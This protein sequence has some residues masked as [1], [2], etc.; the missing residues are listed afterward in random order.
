MRDL[1]NQYMQFCTAWKVVVLA[2]LF[3]FARPVF[4]GNFADVYG[5]H[6]YAAGM[7]G[8][9]TSF[10]N[11]SSAVFYN[12][13]GLGAVSRFENLIARSQKKESQ[14][15][16]SETSAPWW[17]APFEGAITRPPALRPDNGYS[18]ELM[19][20]YNYA[21]P[22][23]K[24]NAPNNQDIANIKDHNAG[25]GLGLN[26]SEVYDLDRNIRFGLEIQTPATGN[27]A[28][29]N[30]LNPTVH[31]YLQNGVS[32]ERPVIMGG[33]GAEIWKDHLFVGV[34]FTMLLKGQGAILLKD[35]PISPQTVVPDQQVILELKPLV[36]PTYGIMFH[37]G[38]F[39]VGVSYRRE[40]YLSVDALSARA[41]TTLL[42]I[43][44]DFDLALLDLHMPRTR[45]Y[46][47][48]YELF[49]KWTL[50]IDI[51]RELWSRIRLSRAKERY[52]EDF[53]FNDITVYRAGIEYRWLDW[54][55]LRGG[56][57]RRPTPLPLMPGRNNWMDSDRMIY[58]VGA[59][60]YLIP[61][62]PVSEDGGLRNPITLDL[63]VQNQQ[64][65]PVD[66]WKYNPTENN[67]FY[68]YSGN[69]W[70]GGLAVTFTL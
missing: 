32:N 47:F 11:D 58:S 7:S 18:H 9:V 65:K 40:T 38:R 45:S 43:Q 64:F 55:S 30:D 22:R 3:I 68:S 35:V 51:N 37:Y 49:E 48:A 15:H 59:S 36:N 28:T 17:K 33:L 69:A 46:G 19:L 29:V 41:Q 67:P 27:L 70:Y 60:L 5:A 16:A 24:T 56:I 62:Y 10:V 26:L 20:M 66:V 25:I 2:A 52:S 6:P 4:A 21:K 63:V 12:V 8:S 14:E 34:G 42:G 23:L 53:Y 50:S 13:A 54:L 57:A 1:V 44:L 61:D 31:R 39:K